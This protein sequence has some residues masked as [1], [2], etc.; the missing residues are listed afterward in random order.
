MTA[1]VNTAQL[2]AMMQ[3]ARERTLELVD[4]LNADQLMGPKIRTVNPLRWEIGHVA[5]WYEYFILRLLDG[6]ESLLGARADEL[7]DSIAV[8][9]D[10]RWDLP[11]LS[12]EDTLD[13]MQGVM[14][15]LVDRLGTI[16]HDTLA[17][18]VD[19]FIY[20]FGV[21][22]EDMHTEAFL[23]A[24]QTLAYPTPKLVMAE[25]VAAERAA[26]PWPG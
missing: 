9:H 23:W 18:E 5:Y 2:T 14:D 20:Q 7:Y 15:R 12:L 17:S 13:Y 26:G 16:S 4:G 25:D 10:T 8:V 3:D 1:Q 6:E 11:L 24:R 22:H 21:F 19:S